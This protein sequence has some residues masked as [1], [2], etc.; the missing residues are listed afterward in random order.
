V[1][2]ST[3]KFSS[4]HYLTLALGLCSLSGALPA[5]AEGL[6]ALESE[7][8]TFSAAHIDATLG[9][10]AQGALYSARQDG[11]GGDTGVTGQAR[12]DLTLERLFDTG[13]TLGARTRVVLYRDTLSDDAYG[14]DTIEKAYFYVQSGYGRIE[15]GQ[16]DGVA[17]VIGLTGPKVSEHLSLDNPETG[18]F[19]DPVTGNR[20]DGFFRPYAV[21]RASSNAAKINYLS[22][23]LLGI[24]IGASYTPS[25][26]KAVLPG[27]G[28][29]PDGFNRQQNI[30]ELAASYTDYLDS[31]AVG[32]SAGYTHGQLANGTLGHDNLSDWSVG[33]QLAYPLMGARLSLGAA[34]RQSNAYLFD[35][36]AVYRDASSRLNS[37]SA[38]VEYDQWLAGAEYS[39]G[40]ADGPSGFADFKRNA[41][42]VSGGYKLNGNMQLTLGW[43]WQNDRRDLGLW[44]N[45][46]PD[47]AMNAAFLALGYEL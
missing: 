24:Q 4:P 25:L 12:A 14:N 16:Q 28:N 11:R 18:F 21:S 15:L 17:A 39:Q 3:L 37:V 10:W 29:P 31:L 47:I 20:A 42:Q 38:L 26:V 45:G 23:R 22:P 40:Q 5:Q 43:R 6:E 33:A 34:H 30:W 46:K 8:F 36:N 44:S 9:G 27:L 13:L 35:N 32:F 2:F 7:P 1:R 41:Y 19:R